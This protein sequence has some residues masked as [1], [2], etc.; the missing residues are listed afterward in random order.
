[1]TS[2]HHRLWSVEL[3]GGQEVVVLRLLPWLSPADLISCI[4]V[5][6]H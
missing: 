1:M 4:S 6:G 2:G 5:A 3:V